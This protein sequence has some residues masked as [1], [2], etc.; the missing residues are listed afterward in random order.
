MMPTIYLVLLFGDCLE[1]D[2]HQPVIIKHFDNNEETN[3]LTAILMKYLV[4]IEMFDRMMLN[5]CSI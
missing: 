5:Q 3:S 4:S 1:H 2:W